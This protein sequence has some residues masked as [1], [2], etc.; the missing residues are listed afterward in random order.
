MQL[1][2]VNLWFKDIATYLALEKIPYIVRVKR[3]QFG[4]PHIG[5][6]FTLRCLF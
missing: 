5:S 1:S 3:N 6:R 2:S 4:N